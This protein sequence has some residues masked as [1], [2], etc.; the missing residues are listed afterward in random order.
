MRHNASFAGDILGEQPNNTTKPSFR[1]HKEWNAYLWLE[2]SSACPRCYW[3]VEETTVLT[4]WLVALAKTE[5][6]FTFIRLHTTNNKLAANKKERA[7]KNNIKINKNKKFSL[8]FF[9]LT[10]END[11]PLNHSRA[12][13]KLGKV[14]VWFL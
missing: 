8:C 9:F 12:E 7:K 2:S 4:G 1:Y 13:A 6:A 14:F 10:T 5:C 11:N 3:I